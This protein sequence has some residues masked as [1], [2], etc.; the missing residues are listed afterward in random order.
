LIVGQQSCAAARPADQ[1][2][3]TIATAGAIQCAFPVLEDGS[4]VDIRIRMVKPSELAAAHSFPKEYVLTGNRTEQVKQIGNSVPVM[5]AAA[6]CESSL[7][8]IR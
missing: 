7:E 2:L 8:N 5:T 6:M 1:P 3:P 4:V